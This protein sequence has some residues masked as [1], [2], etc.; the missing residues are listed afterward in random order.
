MDISLK[1]QEDG[2]TF[3]RDLRSQE[4]WRNVPIIATTA[5]AFAQDRDD[6]LAAGCTA[7]LPKPFRNPELLSLIE[8]FLQSGSDAGGTLP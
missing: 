3:T 7:Y 8:Q 6:A 5:H 4:Q 1:G 2:L